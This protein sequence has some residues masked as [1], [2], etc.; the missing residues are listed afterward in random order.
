MKI[1]LENYTAEQLEAM[2][3]AGE[4]R[5][6]DILSAALKEA[7]NAADIVKNIEKSIYS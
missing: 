6:F 3:E 1:K 4:I 5:E 2:L 7:A